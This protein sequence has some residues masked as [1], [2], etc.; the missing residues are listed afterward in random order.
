[1][2]PE[3]FKSGRAE[4]EAGR[5]KSLVRRSVGEA[6][7]VVSALALNAGCEQSR[8]AAIRA[9]P[10][11]PGRAAGSSAAEDDMTSIGRFAGAKIPYRRVA[12]CQPHL[13]AIQRVEAVNFGT[14]TREF[15]VEVG[16]EVVGIGPW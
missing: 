5:A 9:H 16:V 13:R 10:P 15:L 2:E 6:A 4:Y 8:I 7:W 3:P 12:V 1:E 14:A 11:D